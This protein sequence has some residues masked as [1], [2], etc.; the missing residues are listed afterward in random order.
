[1]FIEPFL[2][3]AR[4]ETTQMS[5]SRG[6]VKQTLVSTNGILLSNK[7]NELLIR[8]TTWMDLKGIMWSEKSQS[9]KG[10]CCMIPLIEDFQNDGTIEVENTSIVVAGDREAVVCKYKG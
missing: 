1:M 2:I 8:T 10:A 6:T 9:E 5:F 7:E 4:L 3:T